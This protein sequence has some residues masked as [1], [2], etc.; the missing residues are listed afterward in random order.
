MLVKQI[1]LKLGL[2]QLKFINATN[3]V[4]IHIQKLFLK[5]NCLKAA[6]YF[7]SLVEKRCLH[8]DSKAI[9]CQILLEAL[10]TKY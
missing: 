1:R 7:N 9:K 3:N 5:I 10:Q 8:F 6:Y 4:F 2:T